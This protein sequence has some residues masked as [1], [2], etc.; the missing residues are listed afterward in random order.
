MDGEI[1]PPHDAAPLLVDALRPGGPAQAGREARAPF[2]QLVLVC[3][4]CARKLDG[5]FGR[6]GK[7]DLRAEL[8]RVFKAGGGKRAYGKARFVES[9][10]LGLCPRRRQALATPAMIE[11]GRL[12]VVDRGADAAA[13]LARLIGPPAA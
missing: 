2:A 3:G 8:K 11:R 6:K 9:S 10:C 7:R 12:L 5:G 4:K 1:P 13:V